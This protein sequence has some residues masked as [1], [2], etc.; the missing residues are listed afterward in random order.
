MQTEK[1][2][3]ANTKYIAISGIKSEHNPTVIRCFPTLVSLSS[4]MDILNDRTGEIYYLV[5]TVTV[6]LLDLAEPNHGF[7]RL[8]VPTISFFSVS[9]FSCNAEQQGQTWKL[10]KHIF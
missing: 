2:I 6:V 3:A 7:R 4:H 10:I 1:G 8:Q 9:S 5:T